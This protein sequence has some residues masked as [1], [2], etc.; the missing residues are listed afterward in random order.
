MRSRAHIA[1]LASVAT[2][3]ASVAAYAVAGGLAE[4]PRAQTAAPQAPAEPLG[5]TPARES[6]AGGGSESATSA[7]VPPPDPSSPLHTDI[8]GCVCHSDDPAIVAEHAQY[9]M[10]QCF[11]CHSDGMP[12]MGAE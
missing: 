3:L 5:R 8:P 11:A 2:L 1:A 4:P 6:E 7:E 12:E 9:R 10:N